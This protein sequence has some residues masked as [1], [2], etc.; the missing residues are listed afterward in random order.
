MMC[1]FQFAPR[2]WAACNGAL[3]SVSQNQALFSLIG[4]FFGGSGR[5][6]FALPNLNVGRVPGGYGSAP[7]LSDRRMGEAYG[8]QA[9]R[10]DVGNLPSHT[11]HLNERVAG[12]TLQLSSDATLAAN[13]TSPDS[14]SPENN[15][16]APTKSGLNQ[17]DSFAAAPDATMNS[18]AIDVETTGTLNLNNLEITNTGE[19]ALIP[20]AQPTL[21]LNFVI[22]TIGT[23]PSRS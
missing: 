14:A 8:T 9:Y 5:T 19:N 11:H 21:I 10:L 2:A 17:L 7:M 3:V 13:K 22:C 15:Y 16:C 12:D 20:M 18:G 1:G 6:D 23:Y 4:T